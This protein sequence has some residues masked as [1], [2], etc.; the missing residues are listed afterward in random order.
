MSTH[1]PE[2]LRTAISRSSTG[3]LCPC[4]Y[5]NRAGTHT[6]S[7]ISPNEVKLP[8]PSRPSPVSCFQCDNETG[9]PHIQQITDDNFASILSAMQNCRHDSSAEVI[10]KIRHLVWGVRTLVW[11]WMISRRVDQCLFVFLLRW[12]AENPSH[13]SAV[14]PCKAFICCGSCRRNRLLRS[15]QNSF[16]RLTCAIA[17]RADAEF[18]IVAGKLLS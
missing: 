7:K 4:V 8:A 9:L 16:S 14:L 17:P 3:G 18:S 10:A 6:Y 5:G 12:P 13:L 11:L 2:P 15:G 1:S